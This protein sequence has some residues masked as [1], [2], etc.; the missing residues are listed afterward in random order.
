MAKLIDTNKDVY[1]PAAKLGVSVCRQLIQ[2]AY[3]LA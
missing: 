2:A 1:E 3:P